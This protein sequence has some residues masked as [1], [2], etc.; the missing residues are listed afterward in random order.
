MSLND[1]MPLPHLEKTNF[2]LL[3][4]IDDITDFGIAEQP[5]RCDFLASQL[6]KLCESIRKKKRWILAN[7]SFDLQRFYLDEIIN[8]CFRL[9]PVNLFPFD[10]LHQYCPHLRVFEPNTFIDIRFFM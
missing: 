1:K 9:F 6:I 5:S 10:F 2:P 8:V 7:V 3:Y 4:N